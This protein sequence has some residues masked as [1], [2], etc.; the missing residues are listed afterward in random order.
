[1]NVDSGDHTLDANLF[2]GDIDGVVI[3]ESNQITD[4][5]PPKN[6]NAIIDEFKKWPGG[7]IPYLYYNEYSEKQKAVIAKAIKRLQEVTCLRM[8]PRTTESNYIYMYPQAGCTSHV[9]HQGI[10][11]QVVSLTKE[12][13][14]VGVILHEFMHAVGFQHEQSRTDRDEYIKINWQNIQSGK[15]LW[16]KKYTLNEITHLGAPYDTCSIMHYV[17]LAFSSNKQPTMEKI[18]PGGCKLGENLYLNDFSDMDIRY[19]TCFIKS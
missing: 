13:F 15:E 12:C 2:E 10:G 9:G 7:V 19:R 5:A 16:F 17:P 18:K 6:R 14:T 1:L 8:V 3:N 11:K 4:I